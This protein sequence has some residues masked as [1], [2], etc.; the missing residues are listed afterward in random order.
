MQERFYRFPALVTGR[1]L[2]S[3]LGIPKKIVLYSKDR[4]NNPSAGRDFQIYIS[5]KKAFFL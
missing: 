2:M 1:N 5:Y 3:S 4:R